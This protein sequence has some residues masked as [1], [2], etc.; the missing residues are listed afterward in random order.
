MLFLLTNLLFYY[1]IL[2]RN[3]I[4]TLQMSNLETLM[5]EI[6][7]NHFD[8]L[9]RE[10]HGPRFFLLGDGIFGHVANGNEVLT[11]YHIAAPGVDLPQWQV[12]ENFLYK[13]IREHIEHGYGAIKT[14]FA[15]CAQKI[16]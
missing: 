7:M 3:D 13:S 1:F 6:Q 4:D 15:L 11:S 5:L 12:N 9:K 10:N 8:G 2:N 14:T 16:F